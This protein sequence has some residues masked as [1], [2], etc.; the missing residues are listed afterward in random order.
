MLPKKVASHSHLAVSTAK[1]NQLTPAII[2]K[3]DAPLRALIRLS[4]T[5]TLQVIF[6]TA[7]PIALV[8]FGLSFLLPEVELRQVVRAQ[9]E[10]FDLGGAPEELSSLEEAEL[11]LDRVVAQEDRTA[12]Y[13]PRWPGTRALTSTRRAHGCCSGSTASVR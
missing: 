12:V 11:A 4:I 2:E 3:L 5:E 10:T 8:A 9:G 6:L 13:S 7:V 1:L